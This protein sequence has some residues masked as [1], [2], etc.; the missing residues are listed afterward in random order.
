MLVRHLASLP[1]ARVEAARWVR[2]GK[3]SVNGAVAVKPAQR[4]FHG[5]EVVVELPPQP[6]APP[7]LPQELPLAVLYEDDHLLAIDKPAGLVVHP[8]WGH[9]DGTLL[10]AL[11]WHARD[12]DIGHPRLV[13][14]LDKD[15]SGVL[16]VTKTRTAHAA[17]ARAFQRRQV[18]KEY[19]AVVHGRPATSESRIDLPIA[20][21]PADPKRRITTD[22]AGRPAATDLELLANSANGRFSLLRCRPTTGRTHQIRVHLAALDLP[23]VGDPLY[24]PQEPRPFPRQALHAFRLTLTH[25]VTTRCLS[26]TAPLPS[27]LNSLLSQLDLALPVSLIEA[28]VPLL[29]R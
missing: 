21:D 24:G 16:L 27:D 3:V 12:W 19:L 22:P 15:T 9:R 29:S 14:R 8:T 18:T 5:D 7:L 25:P 11:L 6:D 28:G 10:N 17:V 23:I 13:H 20:R 2:G 4:L 1:L 26:L